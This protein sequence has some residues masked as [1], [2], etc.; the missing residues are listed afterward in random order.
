LNLRQTYTITMV[1]GSGHSAV[2]TD[3]TGPNKLFAVPANIGS[4]TMPKY[5]E[6]AQQGIYKLDNGIRAFAGTVDDPFYIDLGGT[7]DSLNLRGTFPSGVVGVLTAAQDADDT[8]N[9]APD[10]SADCDAGEG[11]GAGSGYRSE[12]DDWDVGRDLSSPDHDPA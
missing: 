4:R 2:R 6:L 10:S 9:S 8:K 5:T 7:F 3:I 11:R 1:K 12:G